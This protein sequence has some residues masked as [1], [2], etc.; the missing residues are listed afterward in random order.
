LVPGGRIFVL[1]TFWDRQKYA[2]ASYNLQ[3]TSL[4]FASMA[5]GVSRIYDFAS[6]RDCITLAGL[7]I[8]E[9]HDGLGVSHTLLGCSIA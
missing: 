5:N 9:V 3:Q 2:G 6:I 1:E 7:T 4:Y 8:D